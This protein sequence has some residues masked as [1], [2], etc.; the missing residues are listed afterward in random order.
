MANFY[1]KYIKL[2]KDQKID[3][4]DIENRTK[5]N[6]K[7]LEAI[8]N[9][10]FD[11]IQTPYLRLFLKAYINEIGGDSDVAIGELTEFLLKKDLPKSK[12]IEKLES[13]KPVP[14]KKKEIIKKNQP[15]PPKVENKFNKFQDIVPEKT[16]KIT[17][18][19]NILSSNLLKGIL[20]VAFWIIAVVLIR[21]FTLNSNEGNVTES[22]NQHTENVTDYTSFEQLQADYYE[23]SSQQT[24]VEQS[25]PLVIKV[26]S[27]SNLGIVAIQDSTES[28]NIS[29]TA[30]DQQT[31]N[32]SNELE[33]LLNHSD[34]VY[35]FINGDS[36]KDIRSQSEPVKLQFL[37][38][39]KSVMIKHYSK[40]S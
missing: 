35:I 10:N 3:L 28:N 27:N 16:D 22:N 39:P 18:N 24:A 31:F 19:K 40:T 25:L 12:P 14:K 7:Y 29:I 15:S 5:I 32:F 26:V 8:E 6:I 13:D 37:I 33:L 34:G 21:N 9:G 38:E 11:I 17:V 2:R 20:F 4:T 36:V 23:V 30:G 1:E